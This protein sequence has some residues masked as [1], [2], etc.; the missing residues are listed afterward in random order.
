MQTAYAPRYQKTAQL[1]QNTDLNGPFHK[2][3]I[4][5]TQKH[6]KR[7]SASESIR[8]LWISSGITSHTSEWS[9]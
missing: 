5:M 8:E 7:C 2:E 3:D 9:A 1:N 4:E 6:M